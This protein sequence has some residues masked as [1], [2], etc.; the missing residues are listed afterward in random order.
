MRKNHNHTSSKRTERVKK[1][2]HRMSTSHTML[3][4]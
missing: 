3:C 4:I 2:E 1:R